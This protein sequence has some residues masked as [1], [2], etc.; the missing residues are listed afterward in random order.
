MGSENDMLDVR[1]QRAQRYDLTTQNFT[2]RNTG[3]ATRR[4][5]GSHLSRLARVKHFILPE[6]PLSDLRRDS[7]L[8]PETPKSSL[9]NT[10]SCTSRFNKVSN[11][12]SIDS[13]RVAGQ[14]GE[15]IEFVSHGVD[16][17]FKLAKS[18]STLV[19]QYPNRARM[20]IGRETPVTLQPFILIPATTNT[21]ASASNASISKTS[22]VHS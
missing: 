20:W 11:G 9:Y 3:F 16:A 21:N 5:F 15:E 17:S 4:E 1:T 6:K 14:T 7:L 18:L 8:R 13:W 10:G 2:D 22:A 12:V 19:P